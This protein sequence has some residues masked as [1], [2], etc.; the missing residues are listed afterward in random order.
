MLSF[1]IISEV[2]AASDAEPS[3]TGSNPHVIPSDHSGNTDI[4]ERNNDMSVEIPDDAEDYSGPHDD[5][6]FNESEDDFEDE[7]LDD[8]FEDVDFDDDESDNES[9][10]F[11]YDIHDQPLVILAHDK[12]MTDNLK[13]NK[14]PAAPRDEVMGDIVDKLIGLDNIAPNIKENKSKNNINSSKPVVD[15]RTQPPFDADKNNSFDPGIVSVN[16]TAKTL[17]IDKKVKPQSKKLKHTKK[18][19]KVIKK[20]KKTKKIINKKS[21]KASAKK[22]PK[23]QSKL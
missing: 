12:N 5:Y 21:K 10:D 13:D 18:T 15:E 14:N 2:S 23:K 7:D 16:N 6:S 11:D 1:A 4:C 3:G 17:N 19:K 20:P 22:S 8:D 9:F